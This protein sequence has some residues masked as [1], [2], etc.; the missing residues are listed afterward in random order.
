MYT[1]PRIKNGN[2][3]VIL[4]FQKRTTNIIQVQIYFRERNKGVSKIFQRRFILGIKQCRKIIERER[5]VWFSE[6]SSSGW[7]C[8]KRVKGSKVS[9][10][11]ALS[12]AYLVWGTAVFFP[13]FGVKVCEVL[14]TKKPNP[15]LP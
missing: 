10:S 3:G 4:H 2:L 14:S 7:N 12:H 6:T 11:Q 5:L 9:W 8:M 15:G 1:P 13:A